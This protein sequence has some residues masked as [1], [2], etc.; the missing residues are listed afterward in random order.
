MIAENWNL[1]RVLHDTLC[2]HHNPEEADKEN[3]QLTIIVTISNIIAN[4][5]RIG[6]S[7]NCH[8]DKR[9]ASGLLKRL[10]VSWPEVRNIFK[11]VKDEID[12]AKIFLQISTNRSENEN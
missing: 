2:L 12:K 9:M 3:Q 4:V 5:N 6:S 11:T 7:G 1:S 8:P 10:G